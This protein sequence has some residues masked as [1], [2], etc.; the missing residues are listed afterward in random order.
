MKTSLPYENKKE[1]TL[2]RKMYT[3]NEGLKKEWGAR[4]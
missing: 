3:D 1:Q 2:A 4:A